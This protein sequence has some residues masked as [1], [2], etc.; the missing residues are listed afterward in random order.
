MW[1]KWLR[2]VCWIVLAGA[3]VTLL[4]AAMQKKE[5]KACSGIEVDISGARSYFFVDEKDVLQVLKKNGA[6]KGKPV[7]SINL[8]S[9]EA[10]LMKHAWIAEAELFFDTRQVLHAKVVEREPVARVFT[11]QGS[12]FYIDT[13]GHRLPLSDKLTVRVPM[14]SSFP[15]AK[16]VLSKSDSLVLADVKAIAQH[17]IADS[18]LNAQIAQVDITPQGTYELIPVVGRQII[19]I[20]DAQQLDDKF[21]KL[22]LFYTNVWGKTGFEKYEVIDVQYKSQVVAVKR[23]AVKTMMD[24][25]AAMRAFSEAQQQLKRVMNDTLYSAPVAKP[26]TVGIKDTIATADK[27]PAA[28]KKQPFSKKQAKAVMKKPGGG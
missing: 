6:Q 21:K 1:L 12:S 16:K 13:A 22:M 28:T 26:Q 10:A 27:V 25:L 2:I 3:S 15:S 24:T 19:R 23:G 20:G 11:L 9:A 8:H 5:A 17:I 4:V 7:A 18:F 14:F